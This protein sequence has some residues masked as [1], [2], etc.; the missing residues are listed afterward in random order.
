MRPTLFRQEAIDFNQATLVGHVLAAR[1]LPFSVMTA[2]SVAMALAILCLATWGEYTRKVHVSGYLAPTAGLI[3][4]NAGQ[5]GTLIE[6]RVKEGQTVRR[7]DTLFVV[8]AERGSPETPASQ[9]AAIESIK[10]RQAGL[11]QEYE[12]QASIARM[13][14]TGTQERLRGMETE[15]RQLQST[16]ANQ[17]QR[18]ESAE[19]AFTRYEALGTQ[20]FVPEAQVEQKRDELLDQ[21]ARL[22]EIQRA[23]VV[24]DRDISS[25]RQEL[26]SADLRAVNERLRF[27]R[28]H[29]Q[30]TQELTEHELRRAVV[31]TAPIDGI[32]TAVLGDRGQT[33]SAQT[34]L[35]SILPAGAELEVKLLVPSRAI[36]FIAQG[37]MV[38]MRYQAFPYQH[39]GTF[40]GRVTEIP[41]TM[42]APNETDAPVAL[43]ESVYRVTVAIESQGV[44]TARAEVP[45]QAGMLLDADIW[46]ERRR[47]IEWLVEPLFTV[48]RRV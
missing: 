24:L 10:Q 11:N 9:T 17:L 48:A 30:L 43:H 45:L 46:L 35:L 8:S 37:G 18:V 27:E 33:A 21:R 36:G 15:R 19:R 40:K 4:V 42:M 1:R 6:K 41:R 34:L 2:F 5:A 25:H 26:A 39:F 29:A 44:R 16:A 47:L 38:S 22:S 20:R 14:V 31:I 32:V 3:K 28:E 7:G 13:Q 23:Q 12:T